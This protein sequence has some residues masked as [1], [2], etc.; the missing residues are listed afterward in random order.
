MHFGVLRTV[1]AY[2]VMFSHLIGPSVIGWYAVFGFYVLSGFLMTK[3]MHDKYSY[4][5]GGRVAFA[6]NRVLRLFPLYWIAAMFSLSIVMIYG[7]EI[8]KAHNSSIYIPEGSA[9]ISN[10]SMLFLSWYPNSV[11]PR[12]VPPSWAL[13]VEL[14]FYMLICMGIS[15]NVTRVF[16]WFLLS[17]GYVAYSYF[18]EYGFES[19]YFTF[20][21]ASFPFSV[22]ALI[23]FLDKK[24][25]F[26]KVRAFKI[27][28]PSF[29]MVILFFSVGFFVVMKYVGV[30]KQVDY[31][32]YFCFV[33]MVVLI[34]SVVSGKGIVFVSKRVDRIAG[35]L[36]YPM[37]LF[38]WQLALVVSVLMYGGEPDSVLKKI[39]V[40]LGVTISVALV[41]WILYWCVDRPLERLRDRVKSRM[42]LRCENL[43]SICE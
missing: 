2:M 29:L 31:G 6:V 11:E 10:F 30:L 34:S 8:A 39:V 21:A 24:F 40:L 3:V 1:L 42:A 9:I 20:M 43:R 15:K 12:L 25:E 35:C 5:V 13:T 27:L 14:F 37:Y 26:N 7:E 36:S 23:Y 33:V 16:V 28:N 18:Y 22:G 17:V 38:H 41:T 4:T 19:R 32:F